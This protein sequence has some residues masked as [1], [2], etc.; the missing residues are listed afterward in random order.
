MGD[1]TSQSQV[2][3]DVRS[4]VRD[5]NDAL[6]VAAVHG[7]RVELEVI[8]HHHVEEGV[9]RPIVEVHIPEQAVRAGSGTGEP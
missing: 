2:L 1:P 7:I 8:K 6:A 9:P 5:L 4:A 3:Q